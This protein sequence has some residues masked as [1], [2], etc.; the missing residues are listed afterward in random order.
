M[1]FPAESPQELKGSLRKKGGEKFTAKFSWSVES[2][3]KGNDF[4]TEQYC[5]MK[6][7]TPLVDESSE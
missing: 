6:F 7:S 5:R 1:N 2:R 4:M 3:I